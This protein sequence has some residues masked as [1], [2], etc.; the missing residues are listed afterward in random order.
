MPIKRSVLPQSISASRVIYGL[1]SHS[2]N[3]S[4]SLLFWLERKQCVPRTTERLFHQEEGTIPVGT[5]AC[6]YGNLARRV[7]QMGSQAEKGEPF[8]FHP[9][10]SYPFSPGT[11]TQACPRRGVM[12]GPGSIQSGVTWNGV[13]LLPRHPVVM[14]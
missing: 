11:V 3:E 7:S 8:G 6:E 4:L 12:G 14:G 9:A 10:L 2:G 5:F 1:F 13:C